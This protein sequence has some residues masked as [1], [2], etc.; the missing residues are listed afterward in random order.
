[1]ADTPLPTPEVLRQLLRYEPETGKLFWRVRDPSFFKDGV[2][3]AIHQAAIFNGSL[4]GNVA[5]TTLHKQGYLRGR[6]FNK[7]YAAHRVVWAIHY[8][9]WP[10]GEVDHIN[11]QPGDNR[12]CNLRCVSHKENGRNVK[13][14]QNNTSGITGVAWNGQFQKWVAY[15]TVDGKRRHLGVF[16][17]FNEAASAR[18]LAQQQHG[19]HPNHGRS[20]A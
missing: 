12:I 11:G 14:F 7:T 20:A 8:G 16:D 17:D 5:L 9:E 15:I 3:T 1:M 19:F 18:K 13:R 6:V 4:A 10:D 2:K